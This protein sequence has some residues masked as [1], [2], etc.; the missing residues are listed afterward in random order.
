MSYNIN[1]GDNSAG[2]N[3]SE[4]E[5]YISSLRQSS[6]SY[7]GKG[8]LPPTVVLKFSKFKSQAKKIFDAWN[9]YGFSYDLGRFPMELKV[10]AEFLKH[11]ILFWDMIPIRKCMTPLEVAYG[12]L[13]QGPD[14]AAFL[15][16]ARAFTMQHH[17]AHGDTA[18]NE[19][20]ILDG[21]EGYDSIIP[22][23]SLIHWEEEVD[24]FPYSMIP[25]S[26][27]SYSMSEFASTCHAGIVKYGPTRLQIDGLKNIMRFVKASKAAN[28]SKGKSFFLRDIITSL[29][30]PGSGWWGRRTII[31][32]FPGSSRDASMAEPE[33]LTKIKLSAELFLKMCESDPNSAMCSHKIQ[34]ARINRLQ[35]CKMF[36]HLDFKKVGLYLPR[37]YLIS[38]MEE[39]G[40]IYELDVSWFDFEKLYIE[41]EGHTY[42]VPRGYAL[43]WMNEGV[44]LVIIYLIRSFLKKYQL[45][46]EF[47]VFNDDV[48]IGFRKIPPETE[49]QLIRN[50]LIDFFQRA[51]IAVSLKKV[52]FSEVFIFLEEYSDQSQS[53]YNF[54]KR[55]VATRIYAKA[56]ISTYPFMRKSYINIASQL[57][58]S[59]D[60]V[61]ELISKTHLEF[62]DSS[63]PESRL[64]FEIGGF[65]TFKRD[66][67]NTLLVQFP[68]HVHLVEKFRTK[69]PLET[70][71]MKKEFNPVKSYI[72]KQDK[73]EYALPVYDQEK[74]P[75]KDLEESWQ[76]IDDEKIASLVDS[77]P[78]G[79]TLREEYSELRFS[80][81]TEIREGV[82]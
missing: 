10:W 15:K 5:E 42:A 32:S 72:A 45:E 77:L 53:G 54:E 78:E 63:I 43:G 2:L 19:D 4:E 49:M 7:T 29:G 40:N 36:L 9:F 31:Q 14:F 39:I 59:K 21:W 13:V 25:L 66:G 22:E 51:D 41:S 28:T 75:L 6:P 52:Y 73:I 35:G 46:F 27:S 24:D 37:R 68:N 60:I 38:V 69:V 11:N 74:L 71:P 79:S 18:V 34:R 33:T 23:S 1:S 62:P 50:L 3:T 76:D 65:F 30:V 8:K 57:W 17:I 55:S 70:L 48:E 81:A 67:F 64:P 44:T 58:F 26:K 61:T 12:C 80:V 16:K 20:Y 47:L 82:G 56:A